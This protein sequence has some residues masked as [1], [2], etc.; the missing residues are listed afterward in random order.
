[1]S[2]LR[3]RVLCFLLKAC[4]VWLVFFA[5]PD[6][7][8]MYDMATGGYPP[9]HSYLYGNSEHEVCRRLRRVVEDGKAN[10][11]IE[12]LSHHRFEIFLNQRRIRALIHLCRNS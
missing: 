11:Y 6:P 1:M 3:H 5:V 4:L 12:N 8:Q 10:L 7:R 2:S 9:H